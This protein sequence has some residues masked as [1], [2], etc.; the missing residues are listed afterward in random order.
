MD[1]SLPLDHDD[2]IAHV[3]LA[4][5]PVCSLL[6]PDDVAGVDAGAPAGGCSRCGDSGRGSSGRG[7]SSAPRGVGDDYVGT[8]ARRRLFSGANS[9]NETPT[10]V[11]NA[12]VTPSAALAPNRSAISPRTIGPIT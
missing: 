7:S 12:A 1:T 11:M 10:M 6:V 5:T 9:A 8:A 4:A 2:A 3:A